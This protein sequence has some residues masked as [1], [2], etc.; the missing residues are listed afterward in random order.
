MNTATI[1]QTDPQWIF[2]RIVSSTYFTSF[3]VSVIVFAGILVSVETFPEIA[4]QH[5]ASIHLLN[6]IVLAIF[7]LEVVLKI[8]AE[9]AQPWRY[10]KDGWNL[11]DFIIVAICFLPLGGSYVAVLRLFRLLRVIR[12]I[13][14]IPKLQL[15][16]TALLRSL[17]SMFYVCLLL[18]LLFYVYAV[19]GVILFSGNDPVHFGNLWTS[20]LSLFRIV[21]LEDWT[22]VMYE[23]MV[24]YPL[25]WIFYI[26]FIFF[27]AF[28]FLN[29]II[30]IVVG[31]MEH[32]HAKIQKEDAM[33]RGEPTLQDLQD[34]LQELARLVTANSPP[35][36]LTDKI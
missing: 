20:F 7:T 36:R 9:K 15:L 25:S 19:I 31:V 1:Q 11:F 34:Q 2:K 24:V 22:D 32:E 4:T 23:T 10:F 3:I 30:G 18:F 21:T 16:V 27:T 14:V 6:N 17:P 13:T 8:T 33:Q 28:A 26:T 35:E 5:A 12:L 29:M